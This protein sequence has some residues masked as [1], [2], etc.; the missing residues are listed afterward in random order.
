MPD[1]ALSWFCL[2]VLGLCLLLV[3]YLR[4][5]WLVD[6]IYAVFLHRGHESV[7]QNWWLEALGR[8]VPLEHFASTYTSYFPMR[9]HRTAPL[10]ASKKYV[11]G[12]HPH[13]ITAIGPWISLTMNANG[14]AKSLFPKLNFFLLARDSLF[15]LPLIREFALL[16]G[17]RSCSKKSCITHLST[18]GCDGHGSGNAIIIAVGGQRE[19]S[20]AKPGAMELVLAKR[21][22]FVKVAI[23]TGADLVP[24]ISFGENNI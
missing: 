15:W 13:G 10:S 6:S 8:T 16:T 11:T 14:A 5:P 1:Q 20:L 21:K 12:Y 2:P 9:L 4:F 3:P 22:G 7:A 23:E 24:V 18:E 19:V 17:Y